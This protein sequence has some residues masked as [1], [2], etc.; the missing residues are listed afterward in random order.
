MRTS[1][2]SP[3]TSRCCCA[4]RIHWMPWCHRG[5]RGSRSRQRH[6][7]PRGRI[8]PDA[9][10]RQQSGRRHRSGR[11][12]GPSS[13]LL[14]APLASQYDKGEP[15]AQAGIAI[16]SY[17][18]HQTQQNLVIETGDQSDQILNVH[19]AT[20]QQR[21]QLLDTEVKR[22]QLIY[23]TPQNRTYESSKVMLPYS[24][25]NFTGSH[26]TLLRMT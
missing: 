5:S 7:Q 16:G 10:P 25:T 1:G 13:G 19:A 17:Y 4:A 18:L 26:T 8:L 23:R 12:P 21:N 20:E 15:I 14:P 6:Q 3:R 9:G 2:L 11:Y 22:A 24:R